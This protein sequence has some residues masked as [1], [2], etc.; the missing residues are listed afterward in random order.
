MLHKWLL[1]LLWLTFWKRNQPIYSKSYIIWLVIYFCGGKSIQQK[2]KRKEK[3][4]KKRHE[5]IHSCISLK[6]NK[7]LNHQGMVLLN[8]V[9]SILCY[10]NVIINSLKVSHLDCRLIIFKTKQKSMTFS[11]S[12][13]WVGR[14]ETDIFCWWN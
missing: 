14:K 2:P 10:I 13:L 11:N 3:Q 7:Q 6:V 9:T 12:V 4:G 5:D 8:D 1:Q